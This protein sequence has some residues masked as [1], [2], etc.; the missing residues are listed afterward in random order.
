MYISVLLC[1]AAKPKDSLIDLSDE[2]IDGADAASLASQM[3]RMGATGQ[4]MSI[5]AVT[6]H[7]GADEFDM[8]A[9][10]RTEPV[11]AA[12][13]IHKMRPFLH[14]TNCSFFRF[15]NGQEAIVADVNATSKNVVSLKFSFFVSQ[16]FIFRLYL[17]VTVKSTA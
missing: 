16:I 3:S 7:S 4:I 6:T 15:Q 2:A 13:Y 1:L 5:N 11:K 8:L 12:R 14:L 9:Q 10:S 17:R